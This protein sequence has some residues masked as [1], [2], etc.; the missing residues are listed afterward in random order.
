[1]DEDLVAAAR[2]FPGRRGTLEALAAADESFR[3]LCSDLAEAEAALQRWR[4]STL[5]ARDQRCSEYEELVES[6]AGEI[7]VYLDTA[8]GGASDVP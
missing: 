4:A 5:A 1:M 6:L 7:A 2:R 8:E 3:S